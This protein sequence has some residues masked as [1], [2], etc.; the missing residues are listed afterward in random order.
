M[1]L[2]LVSSMKIMTLLQHPQQEETITEKPMVL[3][4]ITNI[5][6]IFLQFIDGHFPNTT[7]YSIETILRSAAVVC[8]T[9]QVSFEATTPVY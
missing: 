4:T 6:R 7:S 3:Y 2:N 9:W 8:Q 5:G 1:D